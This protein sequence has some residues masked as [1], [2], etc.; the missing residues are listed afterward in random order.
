MQYGSVRVALRRL[1]TPSY[2]QEP[3]KELATK[4]TWYWKGDDGWKKYGGK[5]VRCFLH[6]FLM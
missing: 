3:D 4:W 2:I 6:T 5:K 1:S